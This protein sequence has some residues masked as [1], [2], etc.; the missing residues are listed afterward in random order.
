METSKATITLVN[1][2]SDQAD[3][4][5]ACVMALVTRFPQSDFGKTD[6]NGYWSVTYTANKLYPKDTQSTMLRDDS[7]AKL[8]QSFASGFW[9]A[10]QR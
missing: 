2:N 1:F 10:K 9:Y 5:H 6:K 8:V 3:E 7:L 4:A